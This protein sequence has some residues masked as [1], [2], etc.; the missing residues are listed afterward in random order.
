MRATV[1]SDW[2]PI[3]SNQNC[4][5]QSSYVPENNDPCELH[6][7]WQMLHF[8]FHSIEAY[9]LKQ[10]IVQCFL[11]SLQWELNALLLTMLM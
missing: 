7:M 8:Q 4:T 3:H 10:T 11:S 9:K 1:Y 2:H 5:S 6:G